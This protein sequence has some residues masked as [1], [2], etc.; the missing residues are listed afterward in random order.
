VLQL[1]QA[2]ILEAVEAEE[3]KGGLTLGARALGVLVRVTEV[4]L[5]FLPARVASLW[6]FART[7]SRLHG[8]GGI[9][10]EPVLSLRSDGKWSVTQELAVGRSWVEDDPYEAIGRAETWFEGAA[11]RRV[12]AIQKLVDVAKVMES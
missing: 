6:A 12:E 3:Q 9:T 2:P 11:A 10:E 7:L 4:N 8:G 1:R 5:D